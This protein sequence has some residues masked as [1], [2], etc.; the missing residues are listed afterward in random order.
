MSHYSSTTPLLFASKDGHL[1]SIDD[2]PNGSRC[3]CV[4]PKCG[5]KL[6]ARN[7]GSRMQ[8]HF[9]HSAESTC[10]GSAETALHLLVKEVLQETRTLML[11]DYYGYQGTT[12]E[13]DEIILE[14]WQEDSCLR[15]DCIGVKKGHRL[16]IE[17]RVNHAVDED[18]LRYI[19]EHKQG[20]VELDFSQFLDS[21]YTSEDIRKFLANDKT[22]KEWLY[23]AGYYEKHEAVQQAALAK[24]RENTMAYLKA[25]PGEHLFPKEQCTSCPY[26]STRRAISQLLH[27]NIPEYHELI[28]EIEK[29]SLKALKR[30]LVSKGEYHRATV[31]CGTSSISLHN[32]YKEESKGRRLY[33]FFRTVLPTEATRLGEICLHRVF[34]TSDGNIICRCPYFALIKHK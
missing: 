34:Q 32:I 30:P 22:R 19:R 2:V 13:F 11:P 3:G 17:I 29:L 12:I 10:V 25:H 24:E 27:D 33:Y 15:P 18:K 9:A 8:H 20:C 1:V 16:W 28:T 4:C 23:I 21:T 7:G 6:V 31:V 26:H 5:E 14:E